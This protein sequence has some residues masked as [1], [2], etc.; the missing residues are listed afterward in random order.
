MRYIGPRPLGEGKA[1]PS[2]DREGTEPADMAAAAVLPT[3]ETTN[4]HGLAETAGKE[5]QEKGSVGMDGGTGNAYEPATGLQA[6]DAEAG[7]GRSSGGDRVGGRG[8]E[9]GAEPAAGG[10]GGRDDNAAC[11]RECGGWSLC[12]GTCIAQRQRQ[13][14]GAESAEAPAEDNTGAAPVDGTDGA[15]PADGTAATTANLPPQHLDGTTPVTDEVAEGTVAPSSQSLHQ[16]RTTPPPS[17]PSPPPPPP[18]PIPP[19]PPPPTGS[20]PPPPAEAPA[21]AAGAGARSRPVPPPPS[22]SPPPPPPAPAPSASVAAPPLQPAAAADSASPA[23]LLPSSDSSSPNGQTSR[24]GRGGEGG[25]KDRSG[26]G[27]W[28]S[29][30]G[31][32]NGRGKWGS[33]RWDE[34]DGD[35]AGGERP[36]RGERG[37]SEDAV[38]RRATVPLQHTQWA[39]DRVQCRFFARHLIKY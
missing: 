34:S 15:V 10:D 37:N 33:G 28:R 32:G 5:P 23:L 17:L 22:L 6:E 36:L 16:T 39:L 27:E 30:N 29:G 1:A 38:G 14:N 25:E 26:D 2:P 9:E 8:V 21:P 13:R 12:V 7:R 19:P 18:T 35:G 3:T 4:V 31:G 24:A 20:I 11:T